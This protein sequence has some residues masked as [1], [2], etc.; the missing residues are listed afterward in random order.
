MLHLWRM[1]FMHFRFIITHLIK[2]SHCQP[3]HV[4]VFCYDSRPSSPSV[5]TRVYVLFIRFPTEIYSSESFISFTFFFFNLNWH[6]MYEIILC[7]H[8][9]PYRTLN[10]HGM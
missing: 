1:V 2:A 9:S 7:I 6:L 10:Y 8:W 4:L 5:S 3:V